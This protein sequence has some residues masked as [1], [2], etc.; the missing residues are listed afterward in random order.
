MQEINLALFHFFNN[1]ASMAFF[2]IMVSI[3]V[4]LP[5]FVLPVFLL[6]Y[7]I[8]YTYFS[9]DKGNKEAK[10]NLLLIFY[11]TVL[12]L[13]IS[14][15]IQQFVHLDRPEEHI[16]AGAKLLLDHLPDASFPSDHATVSIAFLA[17]IIF[18]GYKKWGFALMLPFILM[19]V[20]RVIAGVHWPFDIIAGS[21]VGI[22]GAYL[23]FSHLSQ[24][25]FVKTLNL[26]I[27]N[28]LK[29]IKL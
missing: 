1:L 5:I 25:K 9:K 8:Y 22:V 15:I 23:V 2:E 21:L 14:L 19:N 24:I 3:F 10:N 13:I 16:Q 28:I 4:D 11:S 18:A 27:I 26:W 20:S 29:H 7:W 17:A 6:G 12:A